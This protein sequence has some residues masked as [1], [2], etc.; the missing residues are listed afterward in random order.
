MSLCTSGGKSY[1]TPV[2]DGMVLLLV[3]LWVEGEGDKVALLGELGGTGVEAATPATLVGDEGELP[4]LDTAG[5]GISLPDS[6]GLGDGVGVGAGNLPGLDTAGAPILLP[7][8][9]GLGDGVG[10]GVGNLPGLDTAGAAIL[11][12]D[13]I[14]LGD[15]V[16]VGVGNLPGLDTA[17]AVILIPDSI[18]LGDGVGVGEDNLPGLDTAGAGVLLL[19]SIGLGDGEGVGEDELLGMLDFALGLAT[20]S[21]VGEE[22]AVVFCCV[23]GTSSTK[24]FVGPTEVPFSPSGAFRSSAPPGQ[25]PDSTLMSS[26]LKNSIFFHK[27]QG[28]TGRHAVCSM[29]HALCNM[30]CWT[31]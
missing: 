21:L 31:S 22:G 17:G 19:G 24:M 23:S 9:I 16:G 3:V 28:N 6:A 2:P 14:G 7:D 25:R 13:S 5:D 29:W 11:L 15:G 1:V 12:P 8:S 4:G 18:G 26:N 20:I 30:C 10:V 27:L